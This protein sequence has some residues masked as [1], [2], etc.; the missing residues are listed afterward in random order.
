MGIIF[1][2]LPMYWAGF[3]QSLMWKQFTESGLLAYP[4]FLE[5]VTQLRPMYALRAFG[6]LLFLIGVFVMVYN[7]IKTASSGEFQKETEDQ[8]PALLKGYKPPVSE[9]W[10]RKIFEWKPV[11][12][13]I[14]SIV[15]I[16]I[17]GLVEIVPTMLVKSNIPTIESV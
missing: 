15:A 4:N 13:M 10:H 3:T 7:L 6:G 11:T 17:G 12:L 14:W 16:S 8:A 9:H 1:Y 5:T 2:A